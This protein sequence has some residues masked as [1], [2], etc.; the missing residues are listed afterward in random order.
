MAEEYLLKEKR[1]H[2]RISLKVPVSVRV[3]SDAEKA[4]GTYDWRKSTKHQNT[5]DVS[6]GGIFLVTDQPLKE[7]DLLSMEI[8]IPGTPEKLGAMAEVVWRNENGG[9]IQFLAMKEEDMKTLTAYL[10]KASTSR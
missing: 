1:V 8:S 3:L 6:L 4:D 5:M 7:K 9:G 10:A 2:P